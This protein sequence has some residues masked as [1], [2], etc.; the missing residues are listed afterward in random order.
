MLFC[1]SN[2]RKH[3]HAGLTEFIEHLKETTSEFQFLPTDEN[4]IELNQ[5]A[6]DI[7][8]KGS[9]NI[10][11]NI[12]GI[13]ENCTELLKYI[14]RRIIEYRLTN[15]KLDKKITDQLSRFYKGRN[16]FDFCRTWEPVLSLYL[17][18]G[19]YS[20]AASFIKLILKMIEK[21]E[22][23]DEKIKEDLNKYLLIAFAMPLGL[24][25]DDKNEIKNHNKLMRAI[26][27]LGGTEKVFRVAKTFRNSN[28]IRHNFVS[29]P[30]LNYTDFKGNLF[31]F[32]PG[33]INEIR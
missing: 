19:N 18:K 28:L 27:K 12:T 5:C 33:K 2:F 23:K 13:K 20:N 7:S 3:S 26:E 16:I 14:W 11:R 9:N 17:I 30:L 22:Y 10:Y 15:Q 24:F 8:Y 31:N 21:L 25:G 32:S 1:L 4:N 29:Y 6:Y